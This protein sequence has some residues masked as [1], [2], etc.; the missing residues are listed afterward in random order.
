MTLQHDDLPGH[1]DPGDVLAPCHLDSVK[2]WT[3]VVGRGRALADEEG[4]PGG[5]VCSPM[6]YFFHT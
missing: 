1:G 4:Q 6:Q 5:Q 2:D 3:C